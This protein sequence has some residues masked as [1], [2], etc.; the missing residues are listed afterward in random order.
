M[1]KWLLHILKELIFNG[2]MRSKFESSL[3]KTDR[4]RNMKPNYLR[5]FSRYCSERCPTVYMDKTRFHTNTTAV[6]TRPTIK[7]ERKN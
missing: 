2:S 4:I 1:I 6:K 3:G 7:A 5:H